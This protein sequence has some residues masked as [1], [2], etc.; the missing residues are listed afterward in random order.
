[1]RVGMFWRLADSSTTAWLTDSLSMYS[2]SL[3][4][5][6]NSCFSTDLT[7]ELCRFLGGL[8]LGYSTVSLVEITSPASSES[9]SAST[10]SAFGIVYD[11]GRSNCCWVLRRC[12]LDEGSRID[13]SRLRLGLPVVGGFEVRGGGSFFRYY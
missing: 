10:V 13:G 4:F 5:I 6:S 9:S 12:R 8:M 11:S 1:M 2:R 7:S 3:V